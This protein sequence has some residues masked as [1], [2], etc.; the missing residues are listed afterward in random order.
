MSNELTP[1]IFCFLLKQG[2]CTCVPLIIQ[3]YERERKHIFKTRYILK[4][5][6]LKRKQ[7]INK[8]KQMEYYRSQY[9]STVMRD[10]SRCNNCSRSGE[11]DDGD[12]HVT[13]ANTIANSNTAV[14]TATNYLPPSKN[15]SNFVNL[16]RI[17]NPLFNNKQ[18]S[19]NANNYN[20]PPNSAMRRA[21][22]NNN[23]HAAMN[24]N[25]EKSRNDNETENH[26]V[27]DL[28][29]HHA[30]MYDY[31]DDGPNAWSLA[32]SST[33]HRPPSSA[34]QRPSTPEK[35]PL[36]PPP[37]LTQSTPSMLAI[38]TAKQSIST[39]HKK[40]VIPVQPVLSNLITYNM[41]NN[42]IANAMR[43]QNEDAINGFGT[44]SL[45]SRRGQPRKAPLRT[46]FDTGNV[47]IR[48][49][50]V[51]NFTYS[52]TMYNFQNDNPAANVARAGADVYTIPKKPS[53]NSSLSRSKSSLWSK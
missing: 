44:G 10:S 22:A 32:N 14:Y 19:Q 42:I 3:L 29:S 51:M 18:Q 15:Y 23:E 17:T 16:S 7:E 46:L 31:N 53:S 34:I 40:Y 1:V 6:E 41:S 47:T 39:L 26:V 20:R 35:Q 37:Q 24:D 27:I 12:N 30:A 2:E 5:Q 38:P 9:N 50:D 11:S 52:N 13:N 33:D 21:T 48:P 4:R 25:P 36:P 28:R 49:R 45:L 43:V 8:Q